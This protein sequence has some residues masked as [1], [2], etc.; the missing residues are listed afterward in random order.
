MDVLVAGTGRDDL[1]RGVL[2]GTRPSGDRRPGSRHTGPGPPSTPGPMVVRP[3]RGWGVM[4]TCGDTGESACRVPLLRPLWSPTRD[5]RTGV[6]DKADAATAQ[7][8][9]PQGAKRTRPCAPMWAQRGRSLTLRLFICRCVI[10]A[11]G[12]QLCP[13]HE[14]RLESQVGGELV[15]ARKPGR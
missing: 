9:A 7:T 1:P 12:P 8:G 3:S 5:W 11:R 13:A 14:Q 6:P 2:W 15:R 10:P 4:R